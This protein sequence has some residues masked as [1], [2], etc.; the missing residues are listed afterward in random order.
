MSKP[1][2]MTPVEFLLG[3]KGESPVCKVFSSEIA[4][5]WFPIRCKVGTK[6]LCGK[7]KYKKET[8]K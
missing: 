8:W 6:F 4:M 3:R 1:N 7:T 2:P 5:H